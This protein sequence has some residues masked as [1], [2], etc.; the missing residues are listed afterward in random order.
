M[1]A[2]EGELDSGLEGAPA[3]K[4]LWW[5]GR[6]GQAGA[7]PLERG[8]GPEP[9]TGSVAGPGDGSWVE[10]PPDASQTRRAASGPA[11]T[12]TSLTRFPDPDPAR[13]LTRAGG[14]QG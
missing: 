9:V 14:P 13:S 8:S 4:L 10:G 2:L 7:G 1:P 11:L 5:W 6:W 3:T 12:R